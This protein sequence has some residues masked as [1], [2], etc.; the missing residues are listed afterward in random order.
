MFDHLTNRLTCRIVFPVFCDVKRSWWWWGLLPCI[1]RVARAL[2]ESFRPRSRLGFARVA[3]DRLPLSCADRDG[4]SSRPRDRGVV[5]LYVRRDIYHVLRVRRPGRL[6]YR[7]STPAS[8]SA[9]AR[10]DF[11]LLR[12]L[13][14]LLSCERVPSSSFTHLR[15][16]PSLLSPLF[17]NRL[18]LPSSFGLRSFLRLLHLSCIL[19]LPF[20]EAALRFKQLSRRSRHCRPDLVLDTSLQLPCDQDL[21]RCSQPVLVSISNGPRALSSTT[22]LLLFHIRNRQLDVCTVVVV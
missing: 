11:R 5:V 21:L 22:H 18:G 17:L 19:C 3:L 14:S 16:S 8:H 20:R 7:A 2:S 15:S 13:S 9:R 12:G 1:V 10:H 4:P 6:G